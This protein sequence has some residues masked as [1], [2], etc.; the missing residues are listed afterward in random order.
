MHLSNLLRLFQITLSLSATLQLTKQK[1]LYSV[2][3]KGITK[4]YSHNIFLINNFI[5]M[6]DLDSGGEGN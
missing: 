3:H 2:L 6:V 5:N 1:K 4:Y